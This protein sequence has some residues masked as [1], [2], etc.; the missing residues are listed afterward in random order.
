MTFGEK[1]TQQIL[2]KLSEVLLHEMDL[3]AHSI[4]A[5]EG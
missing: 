5:A 4:K 1:R 3:P 2:D